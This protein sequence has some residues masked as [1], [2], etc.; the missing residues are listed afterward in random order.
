[1]SVDNTIQEG[2][3]EMNKE[4]ALY[5]EDHDVEGD[6]SHGM[7]TRLLNMTRKEGLEWL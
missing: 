3:L 4:K 7:K 5:G 6:M 2:V 1:M